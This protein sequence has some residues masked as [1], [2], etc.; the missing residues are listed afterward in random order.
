MTNSP[1]CNS[2]DRLGEPVVQRLWQQQDLMRVER[3]ES[4]VHRRRTALQP[5]L[6]DR[7]DLE[8]PVPTTH[9]DIIPYE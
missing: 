3:P 4:L 2:Q 5:P 1:R 6:L 7:L 8:Q 9:T